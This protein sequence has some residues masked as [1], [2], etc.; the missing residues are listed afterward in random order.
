[1][2]DP[3]EPDSGLGFGSRNHGSSSQHWKE[4]AGLPRPG[5]PGRAKRLQEE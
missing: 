3:W 4:P 5:G 1:M 2:G